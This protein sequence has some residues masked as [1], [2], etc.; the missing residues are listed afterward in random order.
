MAHSTVQASS[1]LAVLLCCSSVALGA[2]ASSTE[3]LTVSDVA[4]CTA[5]A[6]SVVESV[7]TILVGDRPAGMN[8][9]LSIRSVGTSTVIV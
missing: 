3:W 4:H 1:I 7:S 6:E 2:P 8:V 5:T 9:H